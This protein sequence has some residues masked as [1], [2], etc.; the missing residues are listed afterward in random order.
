MQ[1]REIKK[2]END[3]NLKRLTAIPYIIYA[4]HKGN[5]KLEF[6]TAR[7][8]NVRD[9]RNALKKQDLERES[10]RINKNNY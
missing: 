7:G 4:N 6:Y 5:I 1:K 3:I 8:K 2:I 9:K 10:Q